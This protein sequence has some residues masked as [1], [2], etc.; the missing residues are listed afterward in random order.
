MTEDNSNKEKLSCFLC[1]FLPWFVWNQT[2]KEFILDNL[3]PIHPMTKQSIAS[4]PKDIDLIKAH[5]VG[6]IP[7]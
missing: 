7:P 6:G 5:V 2:P 3:V 1:G 4:D